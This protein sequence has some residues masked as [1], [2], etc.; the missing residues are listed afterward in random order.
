[1]NKELLQYILVNDFYPMKGSWLSCQIPITQKTLNYFLK[2]L[3]SQSDYIE[4]I[5]LVEIKE[6]V[7]SIKISIFPIDIGLTEFD[8]DKVIKCKVLDLLKPP[9]FVL[10]LQIVDGINF[11]EAKLLKVFINN[12]VATDGLEFDGKTFAVNHR[13]L[14]KIGDYDYLTKKMANVKLETVGEKLF[15]K[16]DLQF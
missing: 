7:A 3:S 13:K 12:I 10:A 9:D 2:D 8:F 4:S 6:D 1:M 15:Y 16:F 14:T 11:I 5:E